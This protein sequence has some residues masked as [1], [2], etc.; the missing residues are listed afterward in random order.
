MLPMIQKR[1]ELEAEFERDGL[2]KAGQLPDLTGSELE[3]IWDQE[4]EGEKDLT[5]IRCG[6]VVI[7][8]EPAFYEGWPRFNQVKEILKEKYGARF[9]SLTPTGRSEY[10]LYGD[11]LN[12]PGRISFT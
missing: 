8:K 6:Q 1:E 4:T 2:K 9:K 10:T 11:D 5:V 3:F 12:S 7:W